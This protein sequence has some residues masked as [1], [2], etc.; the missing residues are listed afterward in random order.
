MSRWE[1]HAWAANIPRLQAKRT[2]QRVQFGAIKLTGRQWYDLVLAETESVEQAEA[3]EQA[4]IWAELK[5]GRT[6]VV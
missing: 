1:K 6:P 5:A 4:Y 2:R 3:A